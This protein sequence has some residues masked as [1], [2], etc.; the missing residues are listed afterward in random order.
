MAERTLSQCRIL[1]V[2]D[3]Y[4]LADDLK[5]E[6]ERAGAIVLGPVSDVESALT[7][8]ATDIRLD[9]AVLDI[10]LGGEPSYPIADELLRR[11][12]PFL[13]TSGYDR[14]GIPERYRQ[15]PRCEKPVRV[16]YIRDA[17]GRIV[18]P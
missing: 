17:I 15:M 9:G 11:A 8:L 13:F 6:L 4:M 18:H 1:V 10:N 12:V 3:E 7:L 14:D 5:E 2:E 16:S